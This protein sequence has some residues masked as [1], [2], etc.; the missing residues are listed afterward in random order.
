MV[1]RPDLMLAMLTCLQA[2]ADAAAPGAAGDD[3][4]ARVQKLESEVQRLQNEVARRDAQVK[5]EVGPPQIVVHTPPIPSAPNYTDGIIWEDRTAPFS[6]RMKALIQFRYQAVKTE[7]SSLLTENGSLLRSA[8]V[9]WDG[10]AFSPKLGFKLEIDFGAGQVTPLDAYIEGRLSPHWTLR[11][12]QVRVPFSRNWMTPEQMLLFPNRPFA[13]EEFRYGYDLG[14][15]VESRWFEGRMSAFLGVFNGAG[16]NVAVNDNVD[17]MLVFRLEGAVMGPPAPLAEGDRRRTPRPSVVIGGTATADYVPAPATYGYTSGVPRSPRPVAALDTNQD[18]RPDGVRVLEGELDVA[19]RW[20]GFAADAELYT[21][22]ET[23]QDIGALQP[24]VQNRF[25]PRADYAGTFAQVSYSFAAGFQV[26]GRVSVT[27]VSPLTVGGRLRSVTTCVGPD[28]VAFDCQVPY[29][30]RR[31]ELSLLA[32][33]SLWD[34]HAVGALMYS[35]L[36]WSATT[37]DGV[38]ASREHD[39]IAQIQ[40][41]L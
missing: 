27:Q 6:L 35:L 1:I 2:P 34:G 8:R 3:V 21:R 15:L 32:A 7:G 40:F 23:W 5:P 4:T 33:Y 26:G 14:A 38:P 16:P 29:A 25:V 10:Y 9:G 19:V 24:D 37:G 12:G 20:R 28:G 31:A 17:P 11:A 22:R 18:G 36:N 30:D 13:I 39:F 41:A